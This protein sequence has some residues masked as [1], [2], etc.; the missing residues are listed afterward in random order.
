MRDCL[1]VAR[2]ALGLQQTANVLSCTL[3]CLAS[4]AG[5]TSSDVA[6][7][8]G[9]GQTQVLSYTGTIGRDS[10]S[11]E[12]GDPSNLGFSQLNGLFTDVWWQQSSTPAS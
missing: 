10:I 7:S 5:Q 11:S 12:G 1:S 9:A 2:T 4:P 3:R 8:S 6:D